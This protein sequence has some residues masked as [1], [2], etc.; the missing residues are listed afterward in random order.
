M[1]S[2]VKA[3]DNPLK[4]ATNSERRARAAAAGGGWLAGA[5]VPQLPEIPLGLNLVVDMQVRL[6]TW[7][8]IDE[9]FCMM[10]PSVV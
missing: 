2:N 9:S 3:H 8:G 5:T 6:D 4:L 10:Y 1:S 7:K